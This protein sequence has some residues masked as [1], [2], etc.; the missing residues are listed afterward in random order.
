[1]SKEELLALFQPSKCMTCGVTLHET[2]TGCRKVEGGC[3]C[4]ECYFRDFSDEL[5]QH[6]I[7]VPRMHRGG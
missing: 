5:E 7:C 4:S 6:P 3:V 1:M 2:M